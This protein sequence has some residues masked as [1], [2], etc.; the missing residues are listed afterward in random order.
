MRVMQHHIKSKLKSRTLLAGGALLM[1]LVI[2]GCSAVNM[3]GFSFPVFGLTKKSAGES[4][5]MIT[6]SIPADESQSERQTG[7][8]ATQ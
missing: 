1:A 7:K 3:T 6:S 2:S 4:D 5:G 8:L